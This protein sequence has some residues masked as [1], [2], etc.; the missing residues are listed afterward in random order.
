MQTETTG[1]WREVAQASW[2][3]RDPWEVWEPGLV[4]FSET[5]FERGL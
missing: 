3:P 1:R 2:S 5:G 4:S